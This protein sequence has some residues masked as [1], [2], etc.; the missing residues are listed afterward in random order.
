MGENDNTEFS[1]G[2][3]FGMEAL[4]TIRDVV[5]V[6]KSNYIVR[7]FCET[8]AGLIIASTG[9]FSTARERSPNADLVVRLWRKIDSN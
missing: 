9:T 5:H 2:E 4:S 1:V 8:T 3:W 6:V 7:L